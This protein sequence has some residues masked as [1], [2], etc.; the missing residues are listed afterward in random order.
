VRD[1]SDGKLSVETLHL[2]GEVE[3]YAIFLLDRQGTIETWNKGASAVKGYQATEIIG[4]SHRVFFS[5]EDLESGLP[6][7]LLQEAS[8]KGKEN[9]E[10]WRIRK[11]GTRFWC[12]THLSARHDE[13]GM[14]AG[15]IEI[16]RDLT[17][18]KVTEE[19]TVMATERLRESN[20]E[21]QRREEKYHRMISEIPDYAILLLDPDGT[22]VDWNKGAEKIKQYKASEIIGRNFRL[23]YSKEDRDAKVPEL[24]LDIARR[25]G[26]M[27]REGWRIRK[28]GTRF[29][30][31]VSLIALHDE[32]GKVLGFSKVTRDLT[33][34]KQ[35]EDKLNSSAEALRQTNLA[36]IQSEERFH[37]MI[38][39]V[40]DYAIILLDT[41]GKILN[42]NAG[43]E[44]IKGYRSGEVI[45]KSFRIFYPPE[46]IERGLPDTLLEEA[47]IEG[48]AAHEG[49]RV[50]KDGSRFWGNVVITALHNE[51]GEH[52][53]FSKVTRDLT[54]KKQADDELREN[55]LE[56][57]RN[58]R[59]LQRLN[60]DLASF[61]YVASH[62]LKEPLRKIQTFVTLLERSEELPE[63][64]R[65]YLNKIKESASRSY[66][67][68]DD[69]LSFSRVSNDK[70][71]F[72]MVDLNEMVA[73]AKDE[74]E[75]QIREKNARILSDHLPTISGVQFQL[76]QL[77]TNL[78][79]NALKFSSEKPLIEIVYLL[80]EYQSPDS[81]HDERRMC[82]H[83]SIADNG[84]GFEQQYA[85]K[86][87]DPFQRLD[88]TT[89]TSGSGIGLAIVKKVIENHGGWIEAEGRPQIGATFHLYFP[90]LADIS[91]IPLRR[92]RHSSQANGVNDRL[93]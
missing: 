82:H 44:Q 48:R 8:L 92:S 52:I 13:A 54:L 84:V 38:A 2:L 53:G 77:F 17:K 4:K 40:K 67:L 63:K 86:I 19:Q 10:G 72:Q 22:V 69:L 23:F 32:Q 81:S 12:A 64:T 45:G 6:E 65:T 79:S 66:S 31:A 16:A 27:H 35:A 68:I 34:R 15:F 43:A 26:A 7:R 36:L 47:R 50:R 89:K 59:M 91:D 24:N 42:W 56:L 11:D 93:K 87:F 9:H 28:D 5:R 60:E 62:D 70:S 76:E 41:E 58:N 71:R 57:S 83:I 3:D 21:L 51:A 85:T 73:R 1:K 20:E 80:G 25:E 37:R 75:F 88:P 90:A 30:A 46:D 61:N 49:W 18:Q 33:E 29:W 55:S 39:E 78:L 14:V 74:M